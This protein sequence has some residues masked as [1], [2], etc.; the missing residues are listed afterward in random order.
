MDIPSEFHWKPPLLTLVL[1]NGNKKLWTSGLKKKKKGNR[2][3]SLGLIHSS[4]SKFMIFPFNHRPKVGPGFAQVKFIYKEVH[5]LN[6]QPSQGR[7]SF[8]SRAC[9]PHACAN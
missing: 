4:H 7:W 5:P 2:C 6:K 8:R 1:Q 3:P 9:G